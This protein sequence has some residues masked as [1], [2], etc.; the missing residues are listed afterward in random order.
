[1]HIRKIAVALFITAGMATAQTS[2]HVVQALAGFNKPND[3][4]LPC[5][6]CLGFSG[7]TVWIQPN[8]FVSSGSE[9]LYYAVFEQNGW[10]GG[11]SVDF[12]LSGGGNIIQD[13]VVNG[14]M[15]ASQSLVVLSGAATIPQTTYS[16]PAALTVTTTGTPDDGSAPVV[17]SSSVAMMIG[18]TGIRGIVQVFAGISGTDPSHF[19]L[20]CTD[21]GPPGTVGVVPM[22]FF[23]PPFAIEYA[24]FQAH[25]WEGSTTCTAT[26]VAQG[27][28]IPQPL[29]CGLVEGTDVVTMFSSGAN[30]GVPGYTGS[31][32]LRV[33]T[34]AISRRGVYQ[35]FVLGSFAPLY[36]E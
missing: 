8:H 2:G 33:I 16:G 18:A 24:V 22:S 28:V 26:L 9:G 11:L 6:G 1:M 20:P 34:N 31:A 5:A 35:T 14:A 12:Q 4:G 27:K 32:S 21:C 3:M 25:E 7:G 13:I 29:S 17:M 10:S 36:F 23:G 15:S 30:P 19:G